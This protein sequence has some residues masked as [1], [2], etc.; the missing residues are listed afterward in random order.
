[1][2]FVSSQLLGR[3]GAASG[4]G[5]AHDRDGDRL[6]LQPDDAPVRPAPYAALILPEGRRPAEPASE[7]PPAGAY[8]P[9]LDFVL[10]RAPG[11]PDFKRMLPRREW[12]R[13]RQGDEEV[14]RAELEDVPLAVLAQWPRGPAPGA[15]P[16]FSRALG[17]AELDR[18]PR[19]PLEGSRLEIDPAAARDRLRETRGALLDMSRMGPSRIT[20]L[21]DRS[22]RDIETS[23]FLDYEPTYSA[24]RPRM[25]V[26]VAFERQAGRPGL[27]AAPL[28]AD[29]GDFRDYD[30]NPEPIRPNPTKASRWTAA[31]PRGE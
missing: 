18:A 24:V 7:A 29:E 12:Q 5:A 16:N 30:P 3:P 27:S 4:D 26:S 10:P 2:P 22:Q 14:P 11:A 28:A 21:T 1:M 19:D 15:I 23:A 20:R 6:L 25:A 8:D 17:R 31:K 9:N 13:R